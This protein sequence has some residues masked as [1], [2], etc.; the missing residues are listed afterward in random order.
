MSSRAAS[1]F[2]KSLSAAHWSTSFISGRGNLVLIA[3]SVPVAGRPLP[4][5]FT[6]TDIDFAIATV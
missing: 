2:D 4:R 5:F 1:A 3:G 6:S